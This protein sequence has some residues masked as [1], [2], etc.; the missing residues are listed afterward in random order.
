MGEEIQNAQ[1]FNRVW[2]KLIFKKKLLGVAMT[3]LC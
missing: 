1:E 3:K 2:V